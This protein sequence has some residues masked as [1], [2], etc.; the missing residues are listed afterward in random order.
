MS[1]FD[2]IAKINSN[3]VIPKES[4]LLNFQRIEI[5]TEIE[6]STK[7]MTNTLLEIKLLLTME[8]HYLILNS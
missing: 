4:K 3:F 2:N 5:P 7:S 1:V 8:T 6:D